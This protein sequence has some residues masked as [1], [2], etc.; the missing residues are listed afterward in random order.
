M[1]EAFA[2]FS[3]ERVE[4][5]SN[6]HGPQENEDRQTAWATDAHVV[7]SN[8][9]QPGRAW[10][11]PGSSTFEGGGSKHLLARPKNLAVRLF[12]AR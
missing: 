11:I 8:S 7:A 3:L 10:S 6:A 5:D 9:P 1:F 12:G 2:L 4:V